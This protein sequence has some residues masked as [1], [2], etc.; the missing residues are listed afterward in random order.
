MAASVRQLA[1]TDHVRIDHYSAVH[2]ASE[3]A[4]S[5]ATDCGLPGSMPDRA[6]VVTSELASN[7]TKH[8]RDG[9]L[10][11]QPLPLGGGLEILAADRG[12][13]MAELERCLVDG[14]TTTGT[15]GAGLGAVRRIATDL[16]ISTH[17][18]EGTFV[19]AR[20]A[21]PGRPRAGLQEVA[22]IRLPAAGEPLCGDNAAVVDHE[23]TRTAA[24]VD[25]LGHGPDADEAA[26]AAIRSF[27]TTADRPLPD[28]V[29]A[30]HRALRHTRG[31]AVGLMRLHTTQA[32]YCGVGNVRMVALSPEGVHHRLIGQ[33]GL[34]G[35]R[36]PAPRTHRVPLTAGTVT[37]L[38]SDGI[39]HRWTHTP[40]HQLLRLPLQL[41]PLAVAERYRHSRDDATILAAK[42]L[43]KGD[44]H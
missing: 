37:A 6:A 9:S 22:V 42:P 3:I 13:G 24:V 17:V 41:L 1:F 28:I 21:Q 15:L 14:Y 25:G 26:Q 34:V 18:G 43:R 2:M 29:T 44:E 23:Q 16:T 7:L 36:M 39:D 8:A 12:P 30:M 33:P 27:H 38:H 11:I 4:R 20:L 5:V 35:F 19:C 31:A 40:P 10:Y 32:E